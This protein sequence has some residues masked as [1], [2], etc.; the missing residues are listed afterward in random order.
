LIVL[1]EMLGAAEM[2]MP[3]TKKL[4]KVSV[5]MKRGMDGEQMN[6]EEAV[7]DEG[8]RMAGLDHPNVLKALGISDERAKKKSQLHQGNQSQ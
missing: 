7:E 1:D 3:S 4:M 2:Q 5:L 8:A 6:K